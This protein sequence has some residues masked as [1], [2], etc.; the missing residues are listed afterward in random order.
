MS[1]HKPYAQ[2]ITQFN[3]NR[4]AYCERLLLLGEKNEVNSV[5]SIFSSRH[6]TLADGQSKINQQI[7]LL[8]VKPLTRET[9]L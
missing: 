9:S 5:F 4:N 8:S 2:H 7:P 1:L 6:F 3:N